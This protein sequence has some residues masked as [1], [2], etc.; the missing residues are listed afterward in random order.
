MVAGVLI[1]E[2]QLIGR[3][4]LIL[5]CKFKLQLNVPFVPNVNGRVAGTIFVSC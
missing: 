1:G 5:Y 3:L 2:N 4:L